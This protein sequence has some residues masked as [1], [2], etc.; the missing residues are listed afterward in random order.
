MQPN[1]CIHIFIFIGGFVI[2]FTSIIIETSIINLMNNRH[3]KKLDINQ[4]YMPD[5]S[6][7]ITDSRRNVELLKYIRTNLILWE[8]IDILFQSSVSFSQVPTS[9]WYYISCA[10][11]R[12]QSDAAAH[13]L[14]YTTTTIQ[15]CNPPKAITAS[16]I[17]LTSIVWVL[18]RI[19]YLCPD[20]IKL[21]NLKKFKKCKNIKLK[22]VSLHC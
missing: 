16:D 13:L 14:L 19:G 2:I 6:I 21:F 4:L 8:K 3:K 9:P 1:Y 17:S 11:L 20:D 22:V 15:W 18:N 5:E 7:I 10:D 12:Y